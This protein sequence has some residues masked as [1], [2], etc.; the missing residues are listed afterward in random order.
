MSSVFNISVFTIARRDLLLASRRLVASRS[1]R[2]VRWDR[3]LARSLG[4]KLC[5]ASVISMKYVEGSEEVITIGK[6]GKLRVTPLPKSHKSV[7]IRFTRRRLCVHRCVN[8]FF[9]PLRFFHELCRR[10]TIG[11]SGNQLTNINGEKRARSTRSNA[12]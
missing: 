6:C 7:W 4:C 11:I 8:S 9:I 3:N 12:R 5:T 1:A 10:D 2:D